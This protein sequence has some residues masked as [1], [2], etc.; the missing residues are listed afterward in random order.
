[1]RAPRFPLCLSARYR[2]L[3]NNEWLLAETRNISA[4]GVLLQGVQPLQVDT[5]VEVQLVL[6][7]D[8][9]TGSAGQVACLGRVV[10]VVAQSERQPPAFAVAIEQY[11]FL[12]AALGVPKS[13]SEYEN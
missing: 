2:P 1:M 10:R 13:V 12:H 6:E 4:S 9:T 3:G 5:Q 8:K 7:S 11:S